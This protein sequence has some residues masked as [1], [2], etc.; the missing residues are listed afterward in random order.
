MPKLKDP[1]KPKELPKQK[2]RG[3][4]KWGG[5]PPEEMT[6]RARVDHYTAELRKRDLQER[7]KELIKATDMEK[8]IAEC[9]KTLAASLE[10][11]SDTLERSLGLSEDQNEK[12]RQVVLN[13][14]HQMYLDLTGKNPE[15]EEGGE[16]EAS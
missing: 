5:V 3:A 12:V 4:D 10:C 16:D 2:Y 13:I 11:L 14:R 15:E 1:N 7:D 6:P 9:F 8:T